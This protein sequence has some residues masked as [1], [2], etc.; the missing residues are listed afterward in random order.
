MKGARARRV[1]DQRLVLAAGLILTTMMGCGAQELPS[2]STGPSAAPLPTPVV[3]TFPID[4]VGWYAGLVIH[5]DTATSVVDEGGGSVTVDIRLENP[6]V[7]IAT[8]SVGILLQAGDRFV[9][10]LRT[11][12]IPDVPA[13]TSVGTTLQ[14]NVDGAF[15]VEDASIRIGRP[16][17]HVL[18]VPLARGAPG[19]ITLEP[20][21]LDLMG[22]AA[23]AALSVTLAG[24]ELRADLPDWGLELPDDTL[25]LSVTYSAKYRG[26]FGGGFAFT[27]ANLAL[28]LP[29]GTVIGARGDG[30]SQSVA[31]LKA[32]SSAPDLHARFEVPAP[33]IGAYA[34]L[35]I[36]GTARASIKFRIEALEPSG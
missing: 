32:G 10:P 7:D 35:V 2:A 14:F 23:T 18:I 12:L 30:H 28:Q 34:L 31:V 19:L 3:A 11:T 21:R 9:E 4:A 5:L 26:D 15:P 13:G 36:D 6:G 24:G 29:D 27:G 20:R 33:G 22:S 8:L 16:G 1:P 17:E 25:A